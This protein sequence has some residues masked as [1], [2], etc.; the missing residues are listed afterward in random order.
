MCGH[1]LLLGDLTRD[2]TLSKSLLPFSQQ[3]LIAS[4]SSFGSELS[5]S[6]HISCWDFIWLEIVWV[7]GVL[8][9][10]HAFICAAAL[11]FFSNTSHTDTRV[12]ERG[13]G[14]QISHLG[15]STRRLSSSAPSLV[16]GS[17]LITISCKKKLLWWVLG[18]TLIYGYNDI[19]GSHFHAM[20]LAEEW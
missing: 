13:H 12:L 3:L 10:L 19:I 8:S 16:V 20:F 11:T 4:T 14:L 9:N 18:N 5:V 1:P 7:L 17:V 15:L 2:S 6:F